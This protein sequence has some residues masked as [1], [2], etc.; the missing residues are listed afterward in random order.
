MTTNPRATSAYTAPRASPSP[1]RL[2]NFVMVGPPSPVHP[3]DELCE[4]VDDLLAADLLGRGQRADL[5]EVDREDLEAL[6]LLRVGEPLVR[7]G[8]LA[9]EQPPHLGLADQVPLGRE[10][11]PLPPR[12]LRDRRALDADE[13]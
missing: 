5:V 12:P 4:V 2:R 9:L 3:L 8:D 13:G 10:L 6:Q 1:R 7:V 11:H